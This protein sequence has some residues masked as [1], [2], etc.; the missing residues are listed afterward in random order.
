[1]L[2]ARTIPRPLPTPPNPTFCLFYGECSYNAANVALTGKNP[3]NFTE[4]S[5][6]VGD[7]A[8]ANH[9]TR[10][11]KHYGIIETYRSSISTQVVKVMGI[12]IFAPRAF[13]IIV[14]I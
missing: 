2:R 13:R 11:F 5:N 10:L 3:D 14:I 12:G 1:M 8:W 6:T 9:N 7:L 4:I